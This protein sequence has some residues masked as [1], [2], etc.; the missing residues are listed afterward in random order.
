MKTWAF[1][2]LARPVTPSAFADITPFFES[3]GD[4][5]K[6]FTDTVVIGTVSDVISDEAV[7]KLTSVKLP[8]V[9]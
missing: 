3:V 4:I 1:I 9:R 8:L 2:Q 6:V 5:F 7:G